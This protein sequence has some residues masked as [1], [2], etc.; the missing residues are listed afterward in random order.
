MSSGT[1]LLNEDGTASMATLL[2]LSHHAFRRDLARFAQA[3]ARVEPNDASRA[4]AL[5]GEWQFYR[6]ALH[7][8]HEMEDANIF[9][10]IR[11]AAPE[12]ASVFEE[13]TADHRRIDPLLARGDA[14]FGATLDLAAAR[15]VVTELTALL[16]SHLTREEATIVARLR[17]AKQFPPPP[18]DAM[19][20]TYAGGFAWSMDGIAEDV[21]VAVGALL[22]EILLAKL[23]AARRAFEQRCVRVWGAATTGSSRTSV[24]AS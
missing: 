14:A 4:E 5:A 24:P 16:D 13:L 1:V 10:G 11:A 12:L 7:G 22:P 2:L 23:P 20:E 17:N 9:P 18:D 21:L 6:G 3:L 19:A 15:G 8:H